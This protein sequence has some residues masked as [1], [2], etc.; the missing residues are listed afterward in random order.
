M[1]LKQAGVTIETSTLKDEAQIASKL[2]DN[3]I[4][5]L[6]VLDDAYQA[7]Y[8]ALRP[9]KMTFWSNSGID[10][11]AKQNKVMRLIRQYQASAA[12]W[13]LVA[14]GVAPSLVQP[15]VF[16]EYDVAGPGARAGKVM[17]MMFGFV[18]LGVFMIVSSMVIDAT[19]GERERR[20]LELLMAQ[21]VAVWDVVLGKWLAASLLCWVGLTL[22]LALV[23][24]ALL[25]LPL[26][27][28]GLSWQLGVW[29]FLQLL[30]S[31]VPLCLLAAAF[32]MALVMNTKS[33]K[34]AQSI[35]SI[36]VIVP[37]IPVFVI[38]LLDLSKQTWMFAVPVTSN[39]ELVKAIAKGQTL[40]PL[41]WLLLAGVPLVAS[42]L[43]VTF[44]ALRLRSERFVIGV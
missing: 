12:E 2:E 32:T 17:S 11:R 36:V 25:Q 14:R 9:A 38:P 41:E 19:A 21:P 13:R 8:L 15:I 10:Q 24:F 31:G 22:Q 33:F 20:T 35:V 23:H 1:Q 43:L 29:G 37:M 27:E 3:K 7:D 18:F 40:V 4:T 6:L 39:A 44:C 42:L 34:E 30:L 16:Q 28:I 26:E 5:G